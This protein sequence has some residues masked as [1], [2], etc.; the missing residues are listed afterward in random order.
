MPRRLGVERVSLGA[1]E[2]VGFY[3]RHGYQTMLLLQ[4]VY[5]G[6]RYERES[7]AVLDGPLKGMEHSRSQF[8][9]V[10]QLFVTLDEPNPTVRAQV[11]DLVAGAHIGYCMTRRLDAGDALTTALSSLDASSAP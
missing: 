1:G 9:G 7:K 3:V 2:E 6:S 5:D 4:C 11:G 10:P 8:N